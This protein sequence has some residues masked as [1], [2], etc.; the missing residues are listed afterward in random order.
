MHGGARTAPDPETD[1]SRSASWRTSTVTAL[2]LV[3]LAAGGCSKGD[4]DDNAA[5]DPASPTATSQPAPPDVKIRARVG[6]VAGELPRQRRKMVARQVGR[7]VDRWFD[8][9]Y[10]GGDYPR[11]SFKDAWPGFT[12]GARALAHRDRKLTSNT[13]LGKRIDG[14]RATTKNVYVD[15][16]SPKQRLAGAT[17]R[18]RLV[19]RTT[20][21]AERRVLVTGRLVL[22]KAKGK[23]KVF[24]FDM[25]RTAVPVGADRKKK[26][27]A[28]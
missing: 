2:L 27:D 3:A 7:V 8:A 4:G 26:G 21:K 25:T 6:T 23:W 18:F 24:G 1:M 15:V 22:T 17:A 28:S 12:A 13:L 10:V 19:F 16:F 9:A 5:S 11:S 20:G 14:A